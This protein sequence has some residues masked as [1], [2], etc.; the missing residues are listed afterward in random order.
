MST[1]D[2]I[3]I[4]QARQLLPRWQ[5]NSELVLAAMFTHAEAL[6][7]FS[8][9]VQLAALAPNLL[10]INACTYTLNALCVATVR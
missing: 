4:G 1:I 3:C 2:A 7:Q 10:I 9:T 6:L 8:G 5:A